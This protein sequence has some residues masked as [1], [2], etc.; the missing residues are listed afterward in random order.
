M[1]RNY[2][3]IALRNLS[4]NVSYSVI[5]IFG[6][7]IGLA[8]AML[9][10]LYTKDEVSFDQFHQNGAHVYRITATRFNPD[11]SLQSKDGNSGYFQ[12]PKFAAYIP[13]IQSFVR[14]QS[15]T[16]DLRQGREVRSQEV[17]FTD[18]SF[19]SVFTFPL[20]SGNPKTALQ[21]PKSVVISEKMALQQFGTTTALGK[22][23]WLKKETTFEPY[24]VSGVARDAPQNSSVKFDVLMPLT[25]EQK[26]LA[27]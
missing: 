6:L 3:K 19:F 8:A 7:S 15:N 22:T 23:I 21:E 26:E 17:F 5:N 16:L 9:I 27:N 25:V 2:L 13:D 10:T 4:R 20:L 18:S 11:G 1:I 24:V 12:G 14:Y